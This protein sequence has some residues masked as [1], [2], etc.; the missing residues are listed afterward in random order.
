MA[1]WQI[2]EKN[3]LRSINNKSAS[4]IQIFKK[5]QNKGG[6]KVVKAEFIHSKRQKC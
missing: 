3:V 6:T 4:T 5:K 2:K 1:D